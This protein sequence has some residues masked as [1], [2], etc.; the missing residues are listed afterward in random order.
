[1]ASSWCWNCLSRL[2]LT[3]QALA[4]SATPRIS[5][6]PFHS[7]ALRYANPVKKK[8]TTLNVQ[9][10]RVSASIKKKKKKP[11]QR[12]S[13][14]GGRAMS[15][16]ERRALKKRIVLSNPNALEIE[17]MVD[18]SAE[19]MVDSRLRG[20]V[21]GLPMPMIDQLR[22]VEA[23]KPKQ[24]WSVFRR[25]GTVLR[26]DTIEM[27]RLIEQISGE[28]DKPQKGKVV[29]KIVNGMKGSGK[30]VHLL[31]AMAMAFLKKWV[32]ITVPDARDLVCANTAYTAVEGT[33]PLQYI[34]PNA[35]S[36][37][38]VRTVE[39]NRDLLAKLK[40]SQKHPSLPMLQPGSTLEDLAKLGFND[41]AISWAVFQAFWAE[42]TASAPAA[43][44]EKGFVARPPMLVTVDGL[45]HWMAESEYRD[46]D[47]NKIHAH[48]LYFVKHFLSLLK[49][50]D[51]LKNGGLLLYATSLSNNPNP[52]ALKI[53][54]DRLAAH[55]AGIS[56]NSPEYPN[57]A[58]YSGVDERVLE[59]LKPAEKAASPLELQILDGITRDEAR[60]FFE[61]FA[62]SGL[63]RDAITEQWVG[64]RWSLSGGGIIGELEKL[65]R[66]F[67]AASA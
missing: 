7:T 6:A 22:A 30:S 63:V 60:G 20:T 25:P 54:M 11:E 17:S 66:R 40:V 18:L 45:A 47:Y 43:G 35:V 67:R 53:A 56:A 4:P 14:G 61:Y 15:P 57:P 34:Q 16:A 48:D 9:K 28:G 1:M 36:A 27:G 10:H 13:G 64:E 2:R 59:F 8:N 5:N 39:A 21:L 65:G 38:L 46:V 62:R 42:L 31:Q 12:S 37:L 29:K 55:Q 19:T 24:G 41:P 58:A 32:V 26:R 52:L 50:G 3:P 23:F 44:L 49:E 51:S 33:K